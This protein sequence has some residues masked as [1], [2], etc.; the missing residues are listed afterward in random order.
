MWVFGY[1][2]L[3]WDDWY[4]SLSCTR[5]TVGLLRGYRRAFNK[6]SVRNWG[7]KE[8]PGPTLNL[9]AD[10][11]AAC[12]GTL[13]EFP[14]DSESEV[15]NVLRDREGKN[16]TFPAQ[17]VRVG[18]CRTVS[19]VVPIYTGKNIIAT[20]MPDQIV[21]MIC[22]AHGENGSCRDYVLNLARHMQSA[23]IVDP[24]VEETVEMIRKRDAQQ[25]N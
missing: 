13:F 15:M 23:G 21:D 9:V 10:A 16:F 11:K 1:G 22:T 25:G 5:K 3:M 4:G 14:D 17:N 18:I 20:A 24:T 2:S 6:K 12:R 19:A 7:T 8:S